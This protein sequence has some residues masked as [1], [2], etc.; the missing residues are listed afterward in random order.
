MNGLV[1][2]EVDLFGDS[3]IVAQDKDEKIW[4]A[5]KWLC[6]GLGLTKGQM[7]NERVKIQEDLALSQ[8]E[9]NLM[10]PTNG[11]VQE[12]LCLQLEFVPLWLAK[13]SI[14]PSMKENNPDLVDKLVKYQL[15]AKDV[16]AKAFLPEQNNEN[17]LIIPKDYPTALRAYADE[18]EKRMLIEQEK[19]TLNKENDLLAQKNLEWADRPLINAII[20]AYGYGIGEDYKTAWRDFKKE[21]LYRYSI[22]LKL[23]KTIHLNNGGSKKKGTLEFIND[24]ELPQALSTAVA[25]CREHNINISD[26]IQKK[27]S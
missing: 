19:E 9:R 13:I 22:N 15:E 12:I 6:N 1:V 14:T 11:G 2:K 7:Q 20:R 3:I 23:R 17:K 5:V 27:I 8:G 16:L 24:S 21:L 10:L 18:Y 25:M 26:I 4:V